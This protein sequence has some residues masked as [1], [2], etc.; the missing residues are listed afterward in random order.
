MIKC[1][2][3]K[4]LEPS[5]GK[6][7][8]LALGHFMTD[9]YPAFLPPL[10]PLLVEKFHLSFTRVGLLAMIFNFSASFTQP[11]FGYFSDRL[12]GWKIIVWAP[13]ISGLSFSLI[14]LA[15]DYS[16]LVLLLIL[17]GLGVASFHPEGAA[18]TASISARKKNLIMSIFMLGGTAGIS[19]GPFLILLIIMTLG[20]EWSLLASLPALIAA[21]LLHKHAPQFGRE[22]SIPASSGGSS[23]GSRL[24]QKAVRFGILMGIVVL[25]ATAIGSLITFLPIIQN[26]RGFSLIVAGSS[27]SIFMVCGALGGL[28]GGYLADQVGRKKI[29]LT[30]FMVMV[31]VFVAFL[32]WKGPVSLVILAFLGFLC[33]LSEPPCIV[34]A[35]EMIPQR[36]R[37]ASSLIMGAAWGLA[38]FG[39]LG[40]GSLADAMGIEWALAFLL[41]FP[42]GALVLS[43]F[44]P[45]K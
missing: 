22:P 14:G 27:F 15:P 38:G 1:M 36:A 37:T 16:Y 24:N 35:Q 32:Y 39:V 28:L 3:G 19:L 13:I 11:V 45:E 12:G 21:W 42:V 34:L 23:W 9:L 20:F 5:F 4:A 26:L 43:L 40:I 7:A 44:L 17:G 33:F 30:S 41:I 29:I 2:S 8:Y 6:A 18:L 31:P 10:L 25:R